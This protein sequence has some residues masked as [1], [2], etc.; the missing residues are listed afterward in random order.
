MTA[1]SDDAREVDGAEERQTR[2]LLPLF[3]GQLIETT[4]R[5]STGVCHQDIDA[6]E[7]LNARGDELFYLSQ[8]GNVGR[9]AEYVRTGLIRDRRGRFRERGGIARAQNEY[10]SFRSQFFSDRATEPAAT[11]GYKCDFVF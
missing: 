5:W 4:G 3:L 8:I 7:A 6:A 10:S 9:H 1:G 2:R 11:G